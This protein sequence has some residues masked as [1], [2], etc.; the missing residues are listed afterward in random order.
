MNHESGAATLRRSAQRSF[1]R[2]YYPIGSTM[3][4]LVQH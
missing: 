4:L 3:K 2:Y 1:A